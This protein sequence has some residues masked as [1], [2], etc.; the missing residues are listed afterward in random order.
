MNNEV[1]VI[2]PEQ[3]GLDKKEADGKAELAPD[4]EKLKIWISN[5]TIDGSLDDQL[6]KDSIVIATDIIDK[7]NAFKKWATEQVNEIK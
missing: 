7:F 6:S 4:K 2:N 1:T 3:F 5:M